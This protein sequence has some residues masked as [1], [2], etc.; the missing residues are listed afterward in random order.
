MNRSGRRPRAPPPV[1]GNAVHS[2]IASVGLRSRRFPLQVMSAFVGRRQELDRL[3]LHLA[4]ARAGRGRVVFITGEPGAG[5]S[6]LVSQ[7]MVDAALKY[8]ETRIIGAVCSE[9]YGA[10]EPYQPF[11][12]AFRSLL[13][14]QERASAKW[15]SLK[16]LAADLAPHWISAIPVAGNL[17]SATITTAVELKKRGGAVATAAPSEE[18]LF[19]QYTELFLAAA[20]RQAIV[21]FIDDLHWA[22]RATVSLLTH[23]ARRIERERVLIIGTY[24]PADVDLTRH[25]IREARLELERYGI[26]EEMPMAPLDSAANADLIREELGGPPT[27]ALLA[28]LERHA[29]SNPLFFVELLK[30]LVGQGL[31]REHHGE[32]ELG[33]VPEAIEIPRSAEATIER[34][35]NRLEPEVYRLLEYASV[36]GNEFG[37]TTLAQLLGMDELELEEALD[38]LARIHQLIR[39]VDTRELP[40][41]DLSSIYQFG[42]SLIQDVLHRNL[43]GKRRVLLHRKMAEI[44]EALYASN[45]AAVV[46]KLAVHFD[47]GRLPAKAYAFAL[48]GARSVRRVYAHRDAIELIQRAQRNAQDNAQRLEAFELLGETSHFIGQYRDALAAFT[49]ALEL[50]RASGEQ[51]REITLRRKLISLERDHGGATPA[52]VE[53]QLM[54]LAQQADAHGAPR[55]VCEILW[56]MITLPTPQSVV[57]ERARAALSICEQEGDPERVARARYNLGHAFAIGP[58]PREAVPHVEAAIR[59]WQDLGDRFRMGD[60]HNL[61][62]VIHG[63]TGAYRAASDDFRAAAQ[64]FD[65]VRAPYHEAGVR[66]NLGVLLTRLGEWEAAEENLREAIR[67][68]LRLDATARLL[69]PLENLAELYQTAGRWN[70]ADEQW[71]VLLEHARSAG[72]WNAEVIARCGIGVAALE[73]GLFGAARAEESAARD[74]LNQHESWSEARTAYHYLSARI[75]A[76]TGEPGSA[77][78]LLRAAEEQLASR[79]QYTWATFRL[80]RAEITSRVDAREAEPLVRDALSAFEQIGSEPMRQRAL[81]LLAITAGAS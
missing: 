38:P 30:W 49:A 50:A 14:E 55:E 48:E 60:C 58:E 78:E 21:L 68:N 17:I 2:E 9:Q 22:D 19:F 43:Q 54:E 80:L 8:P 52:V 72:Y 70:D 71:R 39:L 63:L 76:A 25:P 75:A 31:V 61:L 7:F 35:L 20:A 24:R 13:A 67:L 12:E 37:S 51:A 59:I 1:A 47:E 34:R 29:G 5:K 79:D 73:Q 11:V 23:L 40:S 26:A 74:I 28:W 77:I 66:N 56:L 42:H 18:A 69:H 81:S 27:P 4:N 36:E 62:G 6:T 64:A 32:W 46:H 16:A 33:R 15:A 44:L 65:A 10:A 53:T 57:V 3:H 41:G 45:T